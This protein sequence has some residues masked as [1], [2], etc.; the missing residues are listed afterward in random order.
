M[1]IPMIMIGLGGNLTSPEFGP[2]IKVLAGALAHLQQAGV[3]LVGCSPWYK[4]APIPASDQPWFVN[5]V[6]HIETA[7]APQALLALLH[8]TEVR[9]G[10][11]RRAG[12]ARWAA[13]IIDLDLLAY[14]DHVTGDGETTGSLHLP[15]PRLGGRAFVLAPLAALAPSWRHPVS[16]RTASEMLA[17]LEPGQELREISD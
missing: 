8:R 3:R 17:L 5:G 2:P 4:S 16:G 7:L 14:G 1:G 13:R 15:H 6:A 12:D 11:R 9:L 10:R